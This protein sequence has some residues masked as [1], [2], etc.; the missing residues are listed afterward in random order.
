MRRLCITWFWPPCPTLIPDNGFLEGHYPAYTMV[1]CQR[2]K[3]INTSTLCIHVFCNQNLNCLTSPNSV[4]MV[5]PEA[6]T[7]ARNN[8]RHPIR[9]LCN[10][11]VVITPVKRMNL[12]YD[13][14]MG[15]IF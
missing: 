3:S 9:F 12:R 10:G 1:T 11:N 4:S 7:N 8:H 6:L 15:D 2:K 13:L 5:T 14:E